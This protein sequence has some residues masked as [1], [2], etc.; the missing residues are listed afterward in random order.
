MGNN[1]LYV[2]PRYSGYRDVDSCSIYLLT[3]A[4]K[5]WCFQ[6]REKISPQFACYS[7]YNTLISYITF[8][9][10]F[11]R[12]G[13]TNS[14]ASIHTL[15]DFHK[16]PLSSCSMLFP[17][18]IRSNVIST[19][20]TLCKSL[21]RR[22]TRSGTKPL[23]RLCRGDRICVYTYNVAVAKTSRTDVKRPALNYIAF[24][25]RID[26]GRGAYAYLSFVRRDAPKRCTGWPAVELSA[27]LPRPETIAPTEARRTEMTNLEPNQNF[28][29][30]YNAAA[31][32]KELR[33]TSRKWHLWVSNTIQDDSENALSPAFLKFARTL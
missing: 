3:F 23:Y 4:Q 16:S 14:L 30:F 29:F 1:P 17:F 19:V 6:L 10:R 32:A 27:E 33:I 15:D 20:L 2:H 22:G 7:Y 12:R 18:S 24:P 8:P 28:F 11:L 5:W 9:G 13:L 31:F 26:E 25:W 21:V